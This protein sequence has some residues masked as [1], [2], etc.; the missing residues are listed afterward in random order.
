MFGP[1]G[2]SIIFFFFLVLALTFLNQ[3]ILFLALEFWLFLETGSACQQ[4]MI[5]LP[6]P[7]I[8]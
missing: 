1:C 7:K 8:E 4:K 6:D 2:I 3:V 5:F